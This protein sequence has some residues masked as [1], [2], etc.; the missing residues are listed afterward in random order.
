M[1][2]RYDIDGFIRT[3]GVSKA[4]LARE[5]GVSRQLFNHH[6]KKKDLPV[7]Y[8]KAM[9]IIFDMPIA[10]LMKELEGYCTII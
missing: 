7:S 9:A 8:I 2:I 3:K 10:K 6:C 5:I 4:F 1:I